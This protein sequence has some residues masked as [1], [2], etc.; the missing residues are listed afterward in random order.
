VTAPSTLPQAVPAYLYSAELMARFTAGEHQAYLAA[1]GRPLRP[2]L[3]RA[4]ALADLGPGLDLLDIACGRGEASVHAARRGARVIGL[5]YSE[6]S[7]ALARE[8]ARVVLGETPARRRLSLVSAEAGALP[9][10]D[11]SIDRVI[12]L[13]LIEHLHPWQVERLLAEIRRIIRPEGYVVLHTLPNRWALAVSYP[14]LRLVT[15]GLPAGGRSDYERAVHVNEQ[16]PLSLKRALHRSGF[17]SRVWVEEW[18]TRHAD[19]GKQRAFPDSLRTAAYP[20]LAGPA[21]RRA[22]K[23]VMRSPAA[24]LVGN[25][26]FALARPQSEDSGLKREPLPRAGRFRALT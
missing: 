4:L 11:A 12:A 8:T 22:S 13:D 23:W 1:G 26:L 5:D 14:L 2:R 19:R 7:L 10:P 18:T 17:E 6:G 9:I 15:P 3:A 21:F 24:W 16:S 20:R 25:D